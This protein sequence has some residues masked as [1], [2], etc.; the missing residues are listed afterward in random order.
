MEVTDCRKK[1]QNVFYHVITKHLNV[2]DKLNIVSCS[3][4]FS[5]FSVD[6]FLKR[7][8]SDLLNAFLWKKWW[9]IKS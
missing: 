1:A 9:I 8:A 5:K 2:I 6:Y 3:I 4:F 7:V